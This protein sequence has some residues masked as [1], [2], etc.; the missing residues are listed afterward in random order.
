M[1]GRTGGSPPKTRRRRLSWRVRL[2]MGLGVALVLLAGLELGLRLAGF[3]SAYEM[4][5]KGNW[6]GSPN[7]RNFRQR[8]H[9]S[10]RGFLLNTNGHGLRTTLSE[11]RTPGVLRL[12]VMGDSTA[13]GWGVDDGYTSGDAMRRSLNNM[14][15][16][17]AGGA[18]RV[19]V[20]NAAQSGYTT[21]QVAWLFEKVVAAYK[22]DWVVVFVPLHDY[23]LVLVS[24]K[25]SISGGQ[26]ISAGIRVTLSRHSRIYALLR[27]LLFSQYRDHYLMPDAE[28]DEF[29]VP[30]VSDTERRENMDRMRAILKKWGGKL[31]VGFL[32]TYIDLTHAPG[33]E[34][35]RRMG[36]DWVL[37]YSKEQG[38]PLVDLRNCCGPHAEQA[39]LPNDKGHLSAMGNALV[40]VAAAKV[41]APYLQGKGNTEATEKLKKG[42]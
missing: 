16:R 25:E 5:W 41:L 1:S 19:E 31:M 28:T 39:T 4:P 27:R 15:S 10:R 38:V 33:G 42:R 2:L 17:W 40:G 8:T 37:D 32:P 26:D 18:T 12:A 35:V 29:R 14:S 34:A 23:N 6:L 11:K 13:F 21:T 7:L 20:L 3:R 30:R 9:E 22:P 36:D 24:D